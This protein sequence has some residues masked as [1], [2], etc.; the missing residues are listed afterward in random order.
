VPL[1]G[2]TGTVND[3]TDVW[4]LGYTPNVCDWRVDGRS[5]EE[6]ALATTMTGGVGALPFSID[7]M[8]RLSQKTSEGDFRKPPNMPKI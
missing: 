7:F 4:F 8:K 3:H 6:E 5:R 1:A 2:K